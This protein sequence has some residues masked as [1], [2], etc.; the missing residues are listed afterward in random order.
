MKPLI[1]MVKGRV[2]L[3]KVEND[4]L[5]YATDCGFEFPVPFWDTKGATF[6]PEDKASILMRWIR[7]ERDRVETKA[8]EVA[9][10]RELWESDEANFQPS[11]EQVQWS[12]RMAEVEEFVSKGKL[13]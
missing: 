12:Q 4:A 1:E 5:W 10:M 7:L 6:L 2:K 13:G 8:A 3:V 9:R 11:P